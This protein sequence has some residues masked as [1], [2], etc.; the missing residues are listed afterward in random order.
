M[1]TTETSGIEFECEMLTDTQRQMT[2]I[3]PKKADMLRLAQWVREHDDMLTVDCEGVMRWWFHKDK[4]WLLWG[5]YYEIHSDHGEDWGNW[6]IETEN[7]AIG[8]Y[9]DVDPHPESEEVWGYESKGKQWALRHKPALQPER[10]KLI[11]A[12]K[13]FLLCH[14][15]VRY[16]QGANR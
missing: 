13:T 14:V 11:E 8:G 9:L 1:E 16:T 4:G 5:G 3:N 12:F 10:D 7:D 6:S 15:R 2:L